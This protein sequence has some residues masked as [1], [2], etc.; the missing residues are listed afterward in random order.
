MRTVFTRIRMSVVQYDV[1]IVV[2]LHS[3]NL[4]SLMTNEVDYLFISLLAI[5]MFFFL[6]CLC[7]RYIFF[8]NLQDIVITTVIITVRYSHY[9]FRFTSVFTTFF[10]L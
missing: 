3:F 2:F 4:H 7:M 10:V 6:K 9:S 1:F 5:Q 8:K